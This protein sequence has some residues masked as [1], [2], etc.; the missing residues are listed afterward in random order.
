MLFLSPGFLTPVS[1]SSAFDSCGENHWYNY[2]YITYHDMTECVSVGNQG[3]F[4]INETLGQFNTGLLK[5]I[6]VLVRLWKDTG[7]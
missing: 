1:C 2:V 6:Y 5:I 3:N 4:Y 7:S